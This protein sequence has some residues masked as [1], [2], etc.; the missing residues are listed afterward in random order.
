MFNFLGKKKDT[1]IYSPV[2]GKMVK[3]E[4][5]PDKT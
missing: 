5:V 4:E 3:I 2:I 1:K